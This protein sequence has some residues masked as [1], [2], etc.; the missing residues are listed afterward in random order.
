MNEPAD[1]L[2]C[3]ELVE[4]ITDYVDGAMSTA[5]RARFERHMGECSGCE[6]VV[7]QFRTTIEVTGRLTEEQVSEEQRD[8]MREVFR[9]WRLDAAPSGSE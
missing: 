3:R 6:A 5:D 1:D 2:T 9:R 4:V 8:A 7:S